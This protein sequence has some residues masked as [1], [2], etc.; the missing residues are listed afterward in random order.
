MRVFIMVGVATIAKFV[1]FMFLENTIND[2]PHFITP[3]N[4]I[5][6]VKETLFAYEKK[7]TFYAHTEQIGQ[8]ELLLKMLYY[9][10]IDI[11]WP[12]ALFDLLSTLSQLWLLST[13]TIRH[14]E[15]I[16]LL[17]VFNP[18]TV[19]G[20]GIQNIQS[21]NDFLFVLVVVFAYKQ[22]K[23]TCYILGA[24]ATYFDPRIV[25]IVL[26]LSV[27]QSRQTNGNLLKD[28]TTQLSLVLVV[29]ML[30]VTKD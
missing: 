30:L 3:M 13:V 1:A 10:P 15:I 2:F 17:I 23:Y 21:F 20:G 27:L 8:S 11:R 18:F 19:F 4:D 22:R 16:Q 9:C 26:A 24:L 12:I 28:F 5:R 6:E 7:G 14:K 29:W 25:F